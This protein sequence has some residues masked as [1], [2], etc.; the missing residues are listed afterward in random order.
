MG[1]DPDDVRDM[2]QRLDDA[3]ADFRGDRMPQQLSLL[4]A[5]EEV[6]P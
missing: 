6:T 5:A 4:D 1:L 2:H 3:V